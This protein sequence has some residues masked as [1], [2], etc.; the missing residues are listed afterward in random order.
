M[1]AGSIIFASDCRA[2]IV[3]ELRRQGAVVTLDVVP[4]RRAVVTVET[5]VV[6]A[7]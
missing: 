4:W 3:A 7:I 5:D 1:S 6:T 2:E